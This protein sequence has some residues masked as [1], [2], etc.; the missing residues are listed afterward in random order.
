MQQS[1]RAVLLSIDIRCGL[2]GAHDGVAFRWHAT[3]ASLHADQ[4]QRSIVMQIMRAL[5]A[6]LAA[7]TRVFAFLKRTDRACAGLFIFMPCNQPSE[8]PGSEAGAADS[9]AEAAGTWLTAG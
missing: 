9:S 7:N 6:C 8:S 5:R 4:A 1:V 3:A 2:F